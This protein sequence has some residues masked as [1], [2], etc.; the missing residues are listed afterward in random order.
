[1]KKI[2]LTQGKTAIV[3][4]EDFKR[5]SQYKWYAY[6]SGKT[7][8]ARRNVWAGKK[9]QTVIQMHR[10]IL[11]L[12][13]SDNK[14]VD[15]VNFNGLD[16]RKENIREVP[17]RINIYRRAKQANNTSGFIGVS[18]KKKK[19]LW[20]ARIGING[21]TLSAGSSKDII[22]AAKLRD[23]AAMRHYGKNAIL[24]FPSEVER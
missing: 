18:F 22:K 9:K 24:N 19:G 13:L 3:D 16:N 6:K 1:M 7:F 10:D 21:K 2:L 11:G 8:Y 14:I 15:H 23:L 20:Y 4:D 5:L 17:I 12:S